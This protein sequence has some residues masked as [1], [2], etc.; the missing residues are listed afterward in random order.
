MVDLARI[1]A[2]DCTAVDVPAGSC[3]EAL[4]AA[5]GLIATHAPGLSAR[6]LLEGLLE[7]E[8]LCSTGL[9]E[10]IAVPHCR[11]PSPEPHGALL[12]LR[13]PVDFDAMDDQPVDLLFVLA[14]PADENET[15][16]QTLATL[17]RLFQEPANRERLRAQPDAA[18]LHQ[19][20]LALL[21]AEAA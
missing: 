3:A 9:G 20:F 7:R 5:S 17:V 15:H 19:A 6:V 12:R 10:G 16:L 21:R 1:F 13:A 8:R 4:E 2:R 11:V 18:A 14:V